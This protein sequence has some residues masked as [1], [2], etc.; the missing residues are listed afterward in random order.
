MPVRL[1]KFLGAIILIVLVVV[2]AVLATAFATVYLAESSGWIHLAY[3][4]FTGLLWI[5]PAMLVIKWMETAPR[6]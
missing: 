2:Y 1:K 4:L 3:F 6:R 5:L